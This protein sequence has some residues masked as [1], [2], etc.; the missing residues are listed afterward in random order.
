MTRFANKISELKEHN[1][2]IGYNFDMD[3]H[4]QIITLTYRN[5]TKK[6]NITI[7]NI[8]DYNRGID[9]IEVEKM[10]DEMIEF[11]RIEKLAIILKSYE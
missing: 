5:E 11:L 1:I 8:R 10:F 9:N 6:F 2:K 7:D 4:A 3:T